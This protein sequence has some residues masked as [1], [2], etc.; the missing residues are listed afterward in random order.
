MPEFLTTYGQTLGPLGV[1]CTDRQ[2]FA[3][4]ERLK[5]LPAEDR[6]LHK[7]VSPA[8]ISELAV[9]ERADV[10]WITKE[11]IDRDSEL[12]I[13]AGMD[14]SHFALNP[15]VTCNHAYWRP[16][17][18]RSL[19]R[20][21]TKDGPTPGVK[22]KTVYPPRPDSWPAEAEWEPDSA[23]ALVQAG[24]MAGKSIGAIYLESHAP[25]A[26][27]IRQT[28]ALA[29][30]KRVVD[31]WLLIEYACCWLPSNQGAVTEAVSKSCGP[32]F[33]KALGVEPPPADPAAPNAT[34]P[35]VIPFATETE[36]RAA[37]KTA[38]DR[39]DFAGL[40]A[41]GVTTALDRR[42]GRV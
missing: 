28:P 5:A 8:A 31:K 25:T 29:T 4:E 1:P 38:L 21:R 7:T 33:L 32:E 16:P 10:S 22:A 9:G 24:L 27:D 20:K 17:V 39:L 6:T 3:L 41:E 36:V 13:T 37:V 14:E 12:L 11:V 40:V 42:H 23:F 18:G 19:W 2:A 34:P 26:D 15:L 30:V 35:A